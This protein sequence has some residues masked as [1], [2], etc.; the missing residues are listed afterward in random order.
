[1]NQSSYYMKE[2]ILLAAIILCCL[3]ISG[4]EKDDQPLAPYPAEEIQVHLTQTYLFPGEVLGFKIYCTNPLFPELEL[5]RIAFIE[6]VSD[7]NT[8]V[9]RKK[10]LL[11]HGAGDGEFLLPENLSSGMYTVLVYTNWLKN[12]GEKSFHRE[13]ILIINQWTH[14]APTGLEKIC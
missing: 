7:R 1:M 9:L 12:F 11:E 10:I 8:S 6:L 3:A 5:S 4:Q 14:R 2:S 13:N